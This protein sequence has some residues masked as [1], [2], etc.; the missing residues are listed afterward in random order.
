MKSMSDTGESNENVWRIS[1]KGG[2][3]EY[4][5]ELVWFTSV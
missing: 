4:Q 5:Q 2:R 3:A 1:I